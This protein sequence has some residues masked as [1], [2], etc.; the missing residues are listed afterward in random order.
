MG[1]NGSTS[2]T[3]TTASITPKKDDINF[4]KILVTSASE[5]ATVNGE[6]KSNDGQKHTFTLKVCFYD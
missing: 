4:S 5:I 2:G 1:S 6:A 3:T